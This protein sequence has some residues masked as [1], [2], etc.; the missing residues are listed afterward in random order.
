M[1]DQ[2]QLCSLLIIKNSEHNDMQIKKI[3]IKMHPLSFH[4]VTSNRECVMSLNLVLKNFIHVSI[5]HVY[6]TKGLIIALN[7][8]QV[9]IND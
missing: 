6:H 2:C 4:L 5:L 1:S 9:G 3:N 7:L 8:P